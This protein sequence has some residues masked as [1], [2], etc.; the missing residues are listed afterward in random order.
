MDKRSSLHSG[1]PHRRGFPFLPLLAALAIGATTVLGGGVMQRDA[2][3]ATLATASPGVVNH[4]AVL[5][6]NY[7]GT[8]CPGFGAGYRDHLATLP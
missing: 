2:A 4:Q 5:I 3:A 8:P 6:S 7:D 1:S